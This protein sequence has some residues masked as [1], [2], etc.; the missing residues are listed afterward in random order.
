MTE[1]YC[2][3]EG[4][5]VEVPPR[6]HMCLNHWRMVPK[7]VQELIWKHYRAGQEIDKRPTIEYIAVAFVSVSCVALKEGRPLPTLGD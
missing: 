1:H 6:M 7:A 5:E 2:H 3:A 4:C